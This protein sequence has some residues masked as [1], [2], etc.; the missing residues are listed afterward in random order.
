MLPRGNELTYDLTAELLEGFP[1]IESNVAAGPVIGPY[2]ENFFPERFQK[3]GRKGNTH[4]IRR[5]PQHE[6]IRVAVFP[7]EVC[8]RSIYFN[9]IFFFGLR[10]AA[11]AGDSLPKMGPR[12]VDIIFF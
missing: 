9:R 4:V 3:P 6:G 2:E 12:K 11:I 10:T 1:E 5:V 7:Y 8:I